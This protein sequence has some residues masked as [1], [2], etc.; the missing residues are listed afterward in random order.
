M[1][2]LIGGIWDSSPNCL[3]LLLNTNF[4]GRSDR[5]VSAV[6]SFSVACEAFS[7]HLL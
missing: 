1:E 3:E 4:F 2:F 6:D 5:F 7:D